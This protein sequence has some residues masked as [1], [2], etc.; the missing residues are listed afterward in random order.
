MTGVSRRS[1]VCISRA[2]WVRAFSASTAGYP[3]SSNQRVAIETLERWISVVVRE[4]ERFAVEVPGAEE[5]V[6]WGAH[7]DLPNVDAERFISAVREFL[8]R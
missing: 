6:L 2:P 8:F 5:L 4:S 7:H 1:C 3:L